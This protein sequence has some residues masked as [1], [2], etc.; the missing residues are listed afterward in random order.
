MKA[1]VERGEDEVRTQEYDWA[2][3]DIHD[4]ARRHGVADEDI[5]HAVKNCLAVYPLEQEDS[6]RFLYL[7][8]N[9]A[10]NLLEAVVLEFDDGGRLAIHAMPMLPKYASLL[11]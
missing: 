11:P 9:R 2:C 7:G 1:T 5:H 8:P 10:G 6:A 3:V 4:S